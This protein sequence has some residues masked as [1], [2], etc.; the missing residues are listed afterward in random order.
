VSGTAGLS[1]DSLELV[2]LLLS[3]TESTELSHSQYFHLYPIPPGRKRTLFLASLR[4]RLSALLRS[5]SMTRF[6]YGA[7]L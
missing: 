2:D 6:S 1:N 7:R 4:A 3:T 5:N